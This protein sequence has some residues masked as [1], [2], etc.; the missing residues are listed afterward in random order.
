MGL[1]NHIALYRWPGTDATLTQLLS[2]KN[3]FH[4]FTIPFGVTIADGL[5]VSSEDSTR[6][7]DDHNAGISMKIITKQ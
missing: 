6:D 3:V 2:G 1:A 4:T 5:P 7:I